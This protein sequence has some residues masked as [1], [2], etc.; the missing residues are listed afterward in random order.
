MKFLKITRTWCSTEMILFNPYTCQFVKK[1]ALLSANFRI[2]SI[3]FHVLSPRQT[4]NDFNH[5]S[6]H[7]LAFRDENS[8]HFLLSKH[9]FSKHCSFTKI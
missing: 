9:F 8:L 4:T 1:Q 2:T 5:I 6:E 7:R 3:K